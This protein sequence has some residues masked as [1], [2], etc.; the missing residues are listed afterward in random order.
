MRENKSKTWNKIFLR[1][2]SFSRQMI[3][4][5]VRLCVHSTGLYVLRYFTFYSYV[6]QFFWICN[7]LQF[8]FDVGIALDL[9]LSTLLE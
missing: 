7:Q 9:T 4:S 5:I 6:S 3:L 1:D 8:Y 2:A